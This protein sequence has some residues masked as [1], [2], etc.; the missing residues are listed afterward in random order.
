METTLTR[1]LAVA[2]L[3]SAVQ[4]YCYRSRARTGQ[5]SELLAHGAAQFLFTWEDVGTRRWFELAGVEMDEF[6]SRWQGGSDTRI[7]ERMLHA[8]DA[9][10]AWR[11]EMRHKAASAAVEDAL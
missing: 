6:R 8:W 10:L 5:K 11:K 2:V 7:R 4:D 3:N 9:E 1:S